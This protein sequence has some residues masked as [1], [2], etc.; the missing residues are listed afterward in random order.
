MKYNIISGKGFGATHGWFGGAEVIKARLAV[1]ILFF[2]MA[3]LNKWVFGMLGV[4]FN[5]WAATAGG[6]IVY[7]VLISITGAVK[8]ALG[9]GIVAGIA[10]GIL[11]GA[12]LGST[13]DGG[14]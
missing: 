9:I 8:V 3:I 11:G 4:A 14:E 10:A 6:V 13:A 1:V 5:L 2:L 7:M 12:S